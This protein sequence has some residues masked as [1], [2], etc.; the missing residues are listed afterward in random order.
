MMNWKI[1]I[2]P[3]IKKKGTLQLVMTV[4]KSESTDVLLIVS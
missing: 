3:Q 4:K 1:S 2:A